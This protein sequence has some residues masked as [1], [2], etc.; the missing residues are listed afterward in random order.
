MAN[1]AEKLDTRSFLKTLNNNISINVTSTYI[2]QA[3]LEEKNEEKHYFCYQI[4][5]YNANPFKVALIS[6]YWL[7]INAEGESKEI[8]GAGVLGKTPTIDAEDSFTYQNYCTL[9]T[10]WGTMEGF[11][12]MMSEDGNVFKSEI[13]RFYLIKK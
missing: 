6:R 3:D 1:N 4:T 12:I 8:D 11:F 5:I 7:I 2:S 13:N 9:D 10:D